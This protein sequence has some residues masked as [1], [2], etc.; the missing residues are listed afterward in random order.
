MDENRKNTLMIANHVSTVNQNI[1]LQKELRVYKKALELSCK[2]PSKILER[3][4][5]CI[6]I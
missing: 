1:S 6:N 4:V 2:N 5:K 3:A